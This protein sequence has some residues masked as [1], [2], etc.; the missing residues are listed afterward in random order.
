MTTILTGDAAAFEATAR[1]AATGD[2]VAFVRLIAQH[3]AAMARVAYVICGDAETMQDAVQA[4][5]VTAWRQLPT[6][7]D[8][9]V[10]RAWLLA[11]ASNEC[12]KA[13]RR[14]R[15][16]RPL[17]VS[18]ELATDEAGDFSDRIAAIDLRRALRAIRPEDR[19]LLALRYVAGLDSTSIGAEIGMS[20]SGVRSRLARILGRLRIDL[21]IELE[22]ET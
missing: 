7:R 10:V 14:R 8:A 9:R 20:A 15:R 21:D 2:E 11:I 13:L 17:D 3:H 19:Q 1:A 16:E 6:L 22:T 18:L 5:W 4:A 12:R